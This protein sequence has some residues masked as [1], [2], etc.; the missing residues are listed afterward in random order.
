M[1]LNFS[2]IP[3]IDPVDAE[4][5]VARYKT[6]LIK[7][8]GKTQSLRLALNMIDLTTLNGDDTVATIKQLCHKALH[9]ADNISVVS[10]VAA[11]C[12]YP[13][14]VKLAVKELEKSSVKVASVAGGFP[15]GQ[16]SLEIKIAETKYAVEEGAD[17]IDMVISRGKF[18]DEEYNFVHDEIASMKEACGSCCLKVILETGEL[19]TLN[20]VRIAS[21]IAIAAGADFIKTST[22]KITP[23]ATLESTYVMMQAIADYYERTGKMIG[24]K[25]AG[26]IASAQVAMQYLAMLEDTLGKKWMTNKYFRFGASRLADDLLLQLSTL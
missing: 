22:G 16:T 19:L 5:S 11:V 23:A 9:L 25:P 14:F 4:K 20:N 10:T 2:K 7:N 21:E 13:N 17:E 12:V 18:L 6:S 3:K 24:I 8:G 26:G 1:N 15:S